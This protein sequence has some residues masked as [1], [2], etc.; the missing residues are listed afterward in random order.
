MTSHNLQELIRRS[1]CVDIIKIDVMVLT[2]VHQTDVMARGMARR[3]RKH[4]LLPRSPVI[5]FLQRIIRRILRAENHF[6]IRIITRDGQKV[7]VTVCSLVK[8]VI[9]DHRAGVQ[10]QGVS[11]LGSFKRLGLSDYGAA[12]GHILNHQCAAIEKPAFVR[13]CAERSHGQIRIAACR[14]RYNNGDI[15]LRVR[16]LRRSFR[17]VPTSGLRGLLRRL[18]FSRLRFSGL[19]RSLAFRFTPRAA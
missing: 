19:R 17:L 1:I 6:R 12:A 16:Q 5:K 4:H 7:I 15:L 10:H 8:N 13:R 11:V 3:S 18:C 2:H 9:V 14:E